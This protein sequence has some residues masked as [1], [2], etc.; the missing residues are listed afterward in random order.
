MNEQ[1]HLDLD[2]GRTTKG[3]VVAM[4]LFTGTWVGCGAANSVP[5]ESEGKKVFER[6][7]YEVNPT[8]WKLLSFRKTNGVASVKDGVKHYLMDFEIDIERQDDGE[9][10][11]AVGSI[12]MKMTENGWK[13]NGSSWHQVGS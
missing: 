2:V 9:R 12:D 5:T 7:F 1:A 3:L 11:K 8:N 13:T 4:L 10:Q 6:H